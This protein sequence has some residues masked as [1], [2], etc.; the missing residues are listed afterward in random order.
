MNSQKPEW[1]PQFGHSQL[2]LKL[3][4]KAASVRP[5]ILLFALARVSARS[6][7]QRSRASQFFLSAFS[8]LAT[9]NELALKTTL[10]PPRKTGTPSNAGA[11]TE[12]KPSPRQIAESRNGRLLP[13]PPA[14]GTTGYI[15]LNG[16]VTPWAFGSLI[17]VLA[18]TRSFLLATGGSRPTD[19]G[20]HG[21]ITGTIVAGALVQVLA[22]RPSPA[23][24]G[25]QRLAPEITAAVPHLVHPRHPVVAQTLR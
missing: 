15:P 1:G 25:S 6:L 2:S 11:R 13:L 19:R 17:Q 9:E 12:R 24:A 14:L 8:S 5:E 23:M 21:S 18:A 4:V 3:D 10:L 7:L 20:M 22:V 16:A